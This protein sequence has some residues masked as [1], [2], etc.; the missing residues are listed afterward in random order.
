MWY[1]SS[2]PGANES[3]A[4]TASRSGVFS[5]ARGARRTSPA[6]SCLHW[7]EPATSGDRRRRACI[8]CGPVVV[9]SC[10]LADIYMPGSCAGTLRRNAAHTVF[11][12]P[13]PSARHIIDRAQRNAAGRG[14]ASEDERAPRQDPRSS[15]PR[16]RPRPVRLDTL[17]SAA[18]SD[19]GQ[20]GDRMAAERRCAERGKRCDPSAIDPGVFL[21]FFF[22]FFFWFFS[23]SRKARAAQ[24]R[25]CWG[26]TKIGTADLAGSDARST[27][28]PNRVARLHDPPEPC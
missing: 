9:G 18:E 27:Q 28:R 21:V 8:G 1:H 5:C 24:G 14:S 7:S 25:Q 22:W 13:L 6:V 16:A 11:G 26:C 20:R 4:R 2:P 23:C 17:D 10:G 12:A 15:Q 19:D 3:L